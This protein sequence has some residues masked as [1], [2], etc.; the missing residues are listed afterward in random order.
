MV[1]SYG[2]TNPTLATIPTT[3]SQK[4]YPKNG[5]SWGIW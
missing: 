4:M 5:E 1:W 3:V 2:A